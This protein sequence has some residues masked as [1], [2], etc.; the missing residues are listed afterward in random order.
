MTCL[1]AAWNEDGEYWDFTDDV[2]SRDPSSAYGSYLVD[3][4]T[5]AWD[6]HQT[7]HKAFMAA[8]AALVAAAGLLS[9]A[10][11]KIEVCDT[12]AASEG[13]RFVAHMCVVCGNE[14]DEHEVPS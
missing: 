7:A 5:E 13:S 2:D 14:F 9:D 10:G 11:C 12:F 1:F 6:R 4:E 3:V 8:D